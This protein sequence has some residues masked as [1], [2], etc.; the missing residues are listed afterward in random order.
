MILKNAKNILFIKQKHIHFILYSLILLSIGIGIQRLGVIGDIIIPYTKNEMAKLRLLTNKFEG[1]TLYID[2]PFE[3]Y[4]KLEQDREV[5]LKK[6]ILVKDETSMVS[7]NLITNNDTSRIR[8]RLKGD[9]ASHVKTKKWS[10]RIE[11]KGN[12]TI[13]GMKTFSLQHPDKRNWLNEWL[14]HK[15]LKEE[16]II[17]LRYY[18][19]KVIL[20]GQDLGVYAL[21]EHFDKILI[22]NNQRR[23][24][25]IIRFNESMIWQEWLQFNNMVQNIPYSGYGSY[26][27]SP[28]DAFQTKKISDNPILKNYY[29]NASYLL[30]GF[31][32]KKLSLVDAFDIKKLSKFFVL[33]DLFSAEHATTWNNMRFYYNPIT[34]K[35]EPI[36][37]D[38]M[39]SYSDELII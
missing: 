6:G 16:D 28:I 1:E 36:G 26:A 33:C 30:N 32:E 2:I 21:E 7:A 35:L 11:V 5:A 13:L 12:N 3:N 31:R 18:F 39:S 14:F 8:I 9:W 20:N 24:S 4:K 22:A 10:F 29:I 25:V 15:A 37:F 27:S 38:S 34:K 17:S 23:E 19:V